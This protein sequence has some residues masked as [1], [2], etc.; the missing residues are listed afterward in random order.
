M[1]GRGYPERLS[2][3]PTI[4]FFVHPPANTGATAD[5]HN[6]LDHDHDPV[7]DDNDRATD[8]DDNDRGTSFYVDWYHY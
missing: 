4:L 8:H 2:G 5:H 6:F 3:K 7:H 1:D